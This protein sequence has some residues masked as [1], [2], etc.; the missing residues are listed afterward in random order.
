MYVCCGFCTQ[1]QP[2]GEREGEMGGGRVQQWPEVGRVVGVRLLQLRVGRTRSKRM[3][4][5]E[6]GR[7]QREMDGL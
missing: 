6:E 1:R 2:E 4:D 7:E 3:W 5:G